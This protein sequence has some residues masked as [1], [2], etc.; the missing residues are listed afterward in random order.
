MKRLFPILILTTTLL[1]I[2]LSLLAWPSEAAPTNDPITVWDIYDLAESESDAVGID[3]GFLLKEVDGPLIFGYN[4]EG[5]FGQFYPASTVKVF[6]HLHAMRWAEAQPGSLAD[7][8]MTP[9]PVYKDS[10]S[11]VPN[12]IEIH[13]PLVSVLTDMMQNSDNKMTNAIQLYFGQE[14]INDTIHDI[15]GMSG[16]TN[17]NHRLGCG[18]PSNEPA[19]EMTLQDVT[20]LYEEVARGTLLGPQA[21]TFFEQYM[22]NQDNTS[23]LDQRINNNLNAAGLTNAQ[24]QEFRSL[25]SLAYKDGSY[26]WD[27][28]G[29]DSGDRLY[30]SIAGLVRLP[31]KTCSGIT[32]RT[33][34]YG[35]F[36]DDVGQVNGGTASWMASLMLDNHIRYAAESWAAPQSA[37]GCLNNWLSLGPG[38]GGTLPIPGIISGQLTLDLPDALRITTTLDIQVTEPIT[39]PPVSEGL[40]IVGQPFHIR[41]AAA[42]SDSINNLKQLGLGLTAEYTTD[43]VQVIEEN[44]LMLVRLDETSGQWVDASSSCDNPLPPRLDTDSN[45]ISGQLCELSATYA[46]AGTS[47]TSTLFLPLISR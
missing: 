21:Q 36:L 8:L 5:L 31:Y 13:K 3:Y 17:L 16:W 23:F 26:N 14:A 9:I 46:L 1:S 37:F 19:N 30:R 4:S 44:T 47:K 29:D 41:E 22:L 11:A 7:A 34:V 39:V 32:M 6:H 15:V 12:D 10:C 24:K 45:S 33:F 2:V 35:A 43:D 25:V 18:G 28:D 27:T 40:R 20:L 42:R 38:Q